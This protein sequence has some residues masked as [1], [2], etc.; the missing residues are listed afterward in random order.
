M[1]SFILYGVTQ[2]AKMPLF[3]PRLCQEC[4]DRIKAAVD[5]EF[6]PKPKIEVVS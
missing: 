2:W 5:A 1:G 4:Y 3:S 6:P